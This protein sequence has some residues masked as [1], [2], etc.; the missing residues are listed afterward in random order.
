MGRGTIG[1]RAARR[2]VW[3]FN[4]AP[5]TVLVR[6]HGARF[7]RESRGCN[8]GIEVEVHQVRNEHKKF[9][10]D[11]TTIEPLIA[12]LMKI[13]IAS[14]QGF[15]IKWE[16]KI[17][18]RCQGFSSKRGKNSPFP[19]A[20][21]TRVERRP[22]LEFPSPQAHHLFDETPLRTWPPWRGVPGINVD[23]KEFDF[24][25]FRASEVAFKRFVNRLLELRDPIAMMDT[26]WLRYHILDIDT[27]Y[28]ADANR[29]ISHALQKQARVL[30]VIMYP[31]HQ[32]GLDHSRFASCYLRRTGFSTVI[33]DQGFFKQLEA[34][35]P[36][37]E[38]LFLHQCTIED[39][40]ISSQT[41]KVLTIDRTNFSIAVNATEVQKKFISVPS[42]TSLTMSTPKGLLPMLKDMTLLVT[43]S[44]T[45]SEFGVR[46]DANDFYQYLWSLSGVT[47]LEVNYEGPKVLLLHSTITAITYIHSSLF[48]YHG[49]APNGLTAR[50]LLWLSTAGS[51][52]SRA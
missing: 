32:L 35:C 9:G 16:K 33:L 40:E 48:W 2:F 25:G 11:P 15:S 13:S 31:W 5:L 37:L 46:F 22:S 4:A 1:I 12:N 23:C 29:W 49:A 7:P 28:S 34:G 8:S 3:A 36:A 26:F 24:L 47:N 27:T 45:F 42:V 14:C 41:L 43:A 10:V 17:P 39:D 52:G 44:V 20:L 38:D 21:E 30:E 51:R 19:G 18:I 50:H 6:N